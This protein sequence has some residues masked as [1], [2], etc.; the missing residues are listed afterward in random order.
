LLAES[1][2]LGAD[3]RLT[4]LTRQDFSES[5]SS[6][7]P[8]I[9]TII[10]FEADDATADAL[11]Q[12]L[13]RSLLAE[14]GW[15]ADFRVEDD[16][17]VVFS[18]KIFRYRCGDQAGP[19]LSSMARRQAFQTISWTGPQRFGAVLRAPARCQRTRHSSRIAAG[20]PLQYGG[21]AQEIHFL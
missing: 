20:I 15:Y 17:V 3:L 1:L 16:H 13:A 18:G 6:V 19:R 4:R 14:G 12:S 7:Q 8:P 10:D 5:V 2:R 21:E 9:W 11:A